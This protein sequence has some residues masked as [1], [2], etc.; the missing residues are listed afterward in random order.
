[1]SKDGRRLLKT[2]EKFRKN[3]QKEMQ[4]TRKLAQKLE[5]LAREGAAAPLLTQLSER[6]Q[7]KE[8]QASG[9]VVW[10]EQFLAQSEAAI[11]ADRGAAKAGKAKSKGK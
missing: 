11:A 5:G 2:A 4:Q 9:E 6:L 3:A 1:M 10:S 7:Q 8:L